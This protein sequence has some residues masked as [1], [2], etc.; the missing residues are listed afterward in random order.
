MPKSQVDITTGNLGAARLNGLAKLVD[1]VAQ[2]AL[3]DDILIKFRRD[4]MVQ[5]S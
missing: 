4:N 2:A 1:I 5:Y 3:A